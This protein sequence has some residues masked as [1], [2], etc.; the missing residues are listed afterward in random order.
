MLDAIVVGAGPNGLAA[1]IELASNSYSVEVYEAAETVGGGARTAELTLP[2]FHHD[3]CSAMHPLAAASPFFR[4]LPLE[5]LGAQII[6]PAASAAHP[7]DDGPAAILYPS[8]DQTALELGKDGKKWKRFFAPL[9]KSRT[10]LI[11]QVLHPTQFP[12]NPVALARFGLPALLTAS[13]LARRFEEDQARALFG[14][15]AGHSLL[16]LD[17]TATAGF[18]LVLAILG[19]SPGWP[20]IKGGSQAL[21][22]AMATYLTNLG[23]KIHTSSTVTNIN[24]LPPSR[25]VFF[26]VTPKQLL[27]IC[28]DRFSSRYR[29]KLGKY[30]YGP[31]VFKIDWALDGPVPWRDPR[32]AQSATV[33]LAGRLEE[34]EASESEVGRGQHPTRPYTLFV[35]PTLIDPSRA[36]AG[37][38]TAWAYCHVPHGSDVDMTAAIEA[39]VER[40]APGFKDRIL[41]KH[42]INTVEMQRYNPNYVGG[43]INGGI[44]DLRQ[45][46]GRPTFRF[47]PWTTPDERIFI[48]SS[49]T[50]PGGGV[51][52]MCGYH[53]A[54]SAMKRVLKN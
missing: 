19:H 8:L 26:D 43:D 34:V 13:G 36:P 38:H 40:F 50:P 29:E 37:K 31:G 51:H 45:L 3:V 21:S 25:S 48:C 16:P 41:D 33:H 2:G 24:E 5:K 30:R 27:E 6:T 11:D 35:Q 12:R 32:C 23:G 47:P 9:V 52:G 14:G 28:P 42:T 39:Q 22:D 15:I 49:S 54:R 53:A 44:Q 18:G 1:A 4:K 17:T 10:F 7:L 46:F 20:L